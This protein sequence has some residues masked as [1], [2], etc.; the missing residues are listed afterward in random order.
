M[1]SLCLEP[2]AEN[3]LKAFCHDS[4]SRSEN[5]INFCSFL[6]SIDG[7]FAIALNGQW[8][9]GKTF[10]VRQT[11]LL[12]D[13]TNQF[14][15]L[16]EETRT[17]LDR[18][19][20]SKSE[21]NNMLDRKNPQATVYYNAWENDNHFDPILS[22]IYTIIKSEQCNFIIK[23]ERDDLK[24]LGKLI[25]II[26][27]HNI[28]DFI[29][30]VRGE[31]TLEKI[32]C[33]ETTQELMK[34]LLN[35]LINEHVNRLVIFIDELDRCK[36]TYAIQVLERIKHYFTDERVT[37]VFSINADQLQ[38][39]V[40]NYY[41]VGF[42]ASRYLDKFFDLKMPLPE[43]NY[44]K[45]L[46]EISFNIINDNIYTKVCHEVIKHF[47]FQFRE[48]TRYAQSALDI[49][50]DLEL[51]IKS[52]YNCTGE[53]YSMLFIVPIILGLC[54]VSLDQYNNFIKGADPQTFIKILTRPDIIR[55]QDV[56]LLSG[57]ETA[58]PARVI[59]GKKHIDI[60]EKLARV[61]HILFSEHYNGQECYKLVGELAFE[62][63][64]RSRIIR[65][66]NMLLEKVN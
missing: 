52:H 27:G 24:I 36:P 46:K 42:D 3:I 65:M 34:D 5:V 13:Y 39:T 23:H 22:L 18:Y 35:V 50:D 33:D 64:T 47:D 40:K 63:E 11:K 29:D 53:Q 32:R 14:T 57:G 62:K 15:D 20:Q 30:A 60:T 10:F 26:T 17:A 16:G 12:L 7:C 43:P 31:D 37:F 44:N 59:N 61:Y 2:N 6:N 8:G 49:K 21:L 56:W 54:V 45:F 9:S 58:D 51:R 66:T 28:S 4:I 38:H 19:L 1:K 25:D 41:G 55:Y 48:I